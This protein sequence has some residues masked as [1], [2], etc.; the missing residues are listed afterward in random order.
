M[1]DGDGDGD[2]GDPD[3]A[4]VGMNGGVANGIGREKGTGDAEDPMSPFAMRLLSSV[5][6]ALAEASTPPL[7]LPRLKRCMRE[8][9][10][11]SRRGT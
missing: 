1:G 9:L 11:P 3:I 6:D 5:E 2:E 7:V 8:I 4:G 10:L